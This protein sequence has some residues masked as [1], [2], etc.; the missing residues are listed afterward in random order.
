[1]EARVA[2]ERLLARTRRFTLEPGNEILHHRS[3]MVRRLESLPL[4]LVPA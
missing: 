1:M 3:L 4:M 2:F